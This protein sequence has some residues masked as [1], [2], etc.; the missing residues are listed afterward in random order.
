MNG[1]FINGDI[2][3]SPRDVLSNKKFPNERR[4]RESEALVA[5]KH[6][7]HE[8]T[9]PLEHVQIIT[10][11]IGNETVQKITCFLLCKEK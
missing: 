6:T 7:S 9:Q 5:A 10:T 1:G 8:D 4:E 2:V 11:R 3:L